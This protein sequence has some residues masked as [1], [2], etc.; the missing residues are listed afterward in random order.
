MEEMLQTFNYGIGMVVV[1]GTEDVS[2]ALNIL[3]ESGEEVYQIG[4]IT[5]RSPGTQP[6]EWID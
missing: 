2:T 6:V 1:V 5:P 4:E 3:R